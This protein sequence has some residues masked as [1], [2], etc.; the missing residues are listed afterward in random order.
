MGGPWSL[1]FISILCESPDIYCSYALQLG[2]WHNTFPVDQDSLGRYVNHWTTITST[3]LFVFA[4][5]WFW[6]FSFCDVSWVSGINYQSCP[7]L[8]CALSFVSQSESNMRV[9]S[10][11]RPIRAQFANFF[12][13][14]NLGSSRM[15]VIIRGDYL[16]TLSLL[17]HGTCI[18]HWLLAR[19]ADDVVNY[20]SHG[21]S[22]SELPNTGI[23]ISEIAVKRESK[24]WDRLE[25]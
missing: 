8:S 1:I 18:I 5:H 9:G 20:Q 7:S 25:F 23:F 15:F 16:Y 6:N 12:Q 10:S 11:C 19:E 3:P 22:N 24:N 2:L 17:K 4:S 14:V 13:D 21:C